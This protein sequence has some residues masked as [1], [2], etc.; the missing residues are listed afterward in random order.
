MKKIIAKFIVSVLM[1][2]FL[3]TTVSAVSVKA[4]SNLD[5]YSPIM[6]TS[7]F[8]NLYYYAFRSGSARNLSKE[9]FFA[10]T[11]SMYLLHPEQLVKYDA[12]VYVYYEKMH[13]AHPELFPAQWVIDSARRGTLERDVAE[14]KEAERAGE[15]M[16]A[17]AKKREFEEYQKA[18]NQAQKAFA[19]AQQKQMQDYEKAMNALLGK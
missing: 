17:Q 18:M 5:H 13:K 3:V 8:D 11:F 16:K 2:G 15:E 19:E 6:K 4:D 14:F 7:E 9:N 10:Q 1:V 12:Y